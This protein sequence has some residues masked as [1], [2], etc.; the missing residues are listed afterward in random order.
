MQRQY[1]TLPRSPHHH[2]CLGHRILLFRCH[3]SLMLGRT[4]VLLW[5]W[6][7]LPADGWLWA[8][9]RLGDIPCQCSRCPCE[10]EIQCHARLSSFVLKKTSCPSSVVVLPEVFHLISQSPRV[11]HLYLPISCVSSW[12]F[13][14]ALSV[15]VFQVPM[16]MLF[17]PW[18][19]D[20]APV[21]YLT[22][23]SWCMVK[24]MVLVDP[25]SNQSGMV[26]LCV[27]IAWWVFGK[28][29]P[30]GAHP[31]PGWT[32]SRWIHCGTLPPIWPFSVYYEDNPP[33]DALWTPA[34]LPITGRLSEGGS[35]LFLP[36]QVQRTY[37][38]PTTTSRGEQQHQ[39]VYEKGKR[40]LD[41][42]A[43]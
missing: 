27:V 23:W 16:V 14:S 20:D 5:C 9:W 28:V 12:S 19:F 17:L 30:G 41:R 3:H 43:V 31:S 42:R 18:I 15:L 37:P 33:S 4:L 35:I 8:C 32:C 21:V 6:K 24:G 36:V 26:W 25:G 10:K 34:I 22:P 13:L 40:K 11:F 2:Y 38:L 39:E 7:G 1:P 29:Q